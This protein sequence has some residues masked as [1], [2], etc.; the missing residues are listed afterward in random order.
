M[1]GFR[2]QSI[3]AVM[4]LGLLHVNYKKKMLENKHTFLISDIFPIF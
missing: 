4:L 2:I 3:L 1:I